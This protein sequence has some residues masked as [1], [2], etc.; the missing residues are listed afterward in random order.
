[1]LHTQ[2]NASG[3]ERFFAEKATFLQIN[4]SIAKKLPPTKTHNPKPSQC[5]EKKHKKWPMEHK[6]TR[7]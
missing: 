7:G 3:I 1:M 6:S 5:I 2:S 4:P